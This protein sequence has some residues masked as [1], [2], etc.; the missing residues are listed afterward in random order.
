MSQSGLLDMQTIRETRKVPRGKTR[1]RELATVAERVFLDRGFAGA[2]MQMIATQAGASKE[3]LYRHFVSKEDLLAEI[4]RTRSAQFLGP[5]GE[6]PHGSPAYVLTT[7][8]TSAIEAMFN[9]DCIALFRIVAAETPH[10]PELGAIFYEQGPARVLDR[11]TRYL[12]SAQIDHQI[13]CLHPKQAA[14]LFLGAVVAPFHL[15]RL[16]TPAPKP[17][18]RTIARKHVRAA[19]AMF[20]AKYGVP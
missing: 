18:S 4:V 12:R 11:L 17:L 15:L 1:R 8:G 14:Q 10:A 6:L 7:L 13:H 16:V 19:V 2:T 9:P 5:D 3:T 20:L